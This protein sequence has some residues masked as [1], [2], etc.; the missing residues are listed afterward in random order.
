MAA[1]P[2]TKK[3]ANLSVRSDLLAEAK[4]LNI[5]LSQAFETHL[6]ELVKIKKRERWLEENREAIEAYNRRVEEDGV[7]SDAWRSF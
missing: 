7:F 2:T 3:S 6:S 4:A 5:N 1:H